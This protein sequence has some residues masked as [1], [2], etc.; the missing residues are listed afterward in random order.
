MDLLQTFINFPKLLD[1]VFANIQHAILVTNPEGH[2]LIANPTVEKL[3]GYRQDE[4]EF[5]ELSVIFTPEDLNIFYPNLLYLASQNRPFEG[6]CMLKRKD[7]S[8]FLAYI[9]LLPFS[10]PGHRQTIVV[11]SVQDIDRLK[12][13]ERQAKD[14]HRGDLVDVASGLAHEIRNPLVDIYMTVNRLFEAGSFDQ[15]QGHHYDYLMGSLKRIEDLVRKFETLVTLPKPNF[16]RESTA[17]LLEDGLEGYLD[18]IKAQN[19]EIFNQVGDEIILLD[20]LL[21]TRVLSVLIENAL[22]AMP[23][24]GS[25]MVESETRDNQYKIY[26]TDT[27]SGIKQEDLP[28]IF[29]AF[30]STKDNGVGLDLA[31]VNRILEIHQ[32]TI[33]VTSEVGEGTMFTIKLP[34]ERR[35]FIRN[36]R[37]D[38]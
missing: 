12:A 27:G 35:R 28:F 18:R 19:V 4:L 29:D 3:L 17:Q 24:G 14:S 37:L 11:M 38:E 21:M 36:W 6:E 2:V 26:M 20:R 1:E 16:T 22:E 13:L 32:G 23:N 8:R 31:T 25:L 30:F 34:W 15:G 5:I 7:G 9:T 10:S 33:E